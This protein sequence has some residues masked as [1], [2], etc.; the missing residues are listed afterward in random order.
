VS[1]NQYLLNVI[2]ILKDTAKT[3]EEYIYVCSLF[4]PSKE[5]AFF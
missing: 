2:E 5:F 4:I 1:L 3:I